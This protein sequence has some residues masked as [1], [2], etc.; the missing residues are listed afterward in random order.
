MNL[1]AN[2]GEQLP[3]IDDS[4]E[5]VIVALARSAGGNKQF[6]AM[7]RPELDGEPERAR[8]WLLDCL[9]PDHAQKLSP[10]H[11]LR[12][13]KI[14]RER[15]NH[16][17]IAYLCREAGYT[18]PEPAAQPSHKTLLLSEAEHLAK[19]QRQISEDLDRIERSAVVRELKAT[20]R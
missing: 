18:I 1:D 14:G 11:L 8:R 5:D 12:A 19:R 4:L 13:L 6:A 20:S 7:L 16:L 3:L 2:R 17:L 15:G 10:D 9:N